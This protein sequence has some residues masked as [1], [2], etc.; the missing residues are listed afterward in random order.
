MNA[1]A[2]SAFCTSCTL[3]KLSRPKSLRWCFISCECC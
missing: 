2:L 1:V 3:Q